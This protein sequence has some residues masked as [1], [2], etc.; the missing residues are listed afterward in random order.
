MKWFRDHFRKHDCPLQSPQ[1]R[2]FRNAIANFSSQRCSS[3]TNR[4]LI[5]N[6]LSYFGNSANHFSR[7][8][9]LPMKWINSWIN[10]SCY[11]ELSQ[12][13]FISFEQDMITWF[14]TILKSNFVLCFNPP[15]KRISESFSDF[16]F[17][18]RVF[19][20][21]SFSVPFTNC[22]NWKFLLLTTPPPPKPPHI[23]VKTLENWRIFVMFNPKTL[24]KSRLKT[25]KCALSILIDFIFLVKSV[26][27]IFQT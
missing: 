16:S 21:K 18:L 23:L 8:V 17:C 25:F 11:I 13:F 20:I 9:E 7:R 4:N 1:I 12:R 5:C 27:F 19:I 10:L 22:V 15:S 2:K 24:S 3:S 14:V 6:V 26:D